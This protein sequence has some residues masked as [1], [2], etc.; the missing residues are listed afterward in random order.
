MG[1]YTAILIIAVILLGVYFDGPS[2]RRNLRSL[3]QFGQ[4]ALLALLPIYVVDL[5]VQYRRVGSFRL[6]LKRHWLTI[7]MTIPYLRVL[8][9]ARLARLTR[10]MRL[11]KLAKIGR[12]PGLQRVEQ[13]RRKGVRLLHRGKRVQS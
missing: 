7:L 5:G 3:G 2:D 6:F 9:L 1:T 13:A 4:T 8:R 10:V 12:W 11:V